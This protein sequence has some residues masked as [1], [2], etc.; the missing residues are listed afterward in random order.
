MLSNVEQV[1][2]RVKTREERWAGTCLGPCV[3]STQVLLWTSPRDFE[4]ESEDPR[5]HVVFAS[6]GQLRDVHLQTCMFHLDTLD[7]VPI[8]D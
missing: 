3:T 7:P 8:T 5:A 4:L 1:S 2:G 6:S